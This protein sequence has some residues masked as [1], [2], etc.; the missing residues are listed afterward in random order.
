MGELSDLIQQYGY[1]AVF[2]GTFVEGE[3]IA[4]LGGFLAHG[5]YLTLTW[6]MIISF[7]GSFS[8]DQTAYW[9][10]RRYGSRWKPKSALVRER[11]AHAE[12]ALDR[13][14]IPVL[15]GFRFVYGIRNATPFVAGSITKIPVWRFI[16]L[17]AAGAAIWSTSIPAIGY[18]FGET[19]ESLLGKRKVYEWR[20][21]AA[22]VAIALLIWA[23]RYLRERRR[24][25]RSNATD[26]ASPHRTQ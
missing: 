17:N 22:I 8:G 7:I 10:G 9:L 3:S 6:V 20:M 12:R 24:A 25:V 13:Y 5:G 19:V 18:Y 16:L 4:L 15:L 21:L 11:I 23:V 26:A 1:V 14:Q 2:L